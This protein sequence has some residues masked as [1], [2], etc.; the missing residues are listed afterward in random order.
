MCAKQC[1][2][3]KRKKK[4]RQ[5]HKREASTRLA[6]KAKNTINESKSQKIPKKVETLSAKI[7]KRSTERRLVSPGTR[8]LNDC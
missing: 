6:R 4:A 1:L 8:N 7:K 3:K 2:K 5:E